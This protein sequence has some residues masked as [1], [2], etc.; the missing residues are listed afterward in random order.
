MRQQV[1][2]KQFGSKALLEEVIFRSYVELVNK[3]Y[4]KNGKNNN[5]FLRELGSL[6]SNTTITDLEPEFKAD[7]S[8]ITHSLIAY[9]HQQGFVLVPKKD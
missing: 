2:N 8:S 5:V 1:Q 4:R 7:I 6:H 3:R 9:M